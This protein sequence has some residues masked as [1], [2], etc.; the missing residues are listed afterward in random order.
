[1]AYFYHTNSKMVENCVVLVYK[2]IVFIQNGNINVG[3]YIVAVGDM[4]TKR[5]KHDEVV[6]LVRKSGSSLK[7]K[8]ITPMQQDNLEVP[9][10]ASTPST[11]KTPMRM[12]S[13][14]HSLSGAS[15]K[16]SKSRLSTPWIFA[17][18]GSKDK[19]DGSK[20]EEFMLVGD[21]SDKFS[22]HDILM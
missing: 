6:S 21:D 3:D 4:D 1:M 10:P 15:S 19:D 20:N 9:G 17:K 7:L 14:G 11:P 13:P 16:S 5:A 2:F 22:D 12:Q 8:L 18:K